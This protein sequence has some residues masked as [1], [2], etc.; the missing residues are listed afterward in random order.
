MLE[1]SLSAFTV[2][3][4]TIRAKQEMQYR[5]RGGLPTF[6][7]HHEPQQPNCC[8]GAHYQLEEG[9]DITD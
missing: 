9:S 4:N 7:Q 2:G 1:T 8:M 6:T 3:R 5:E